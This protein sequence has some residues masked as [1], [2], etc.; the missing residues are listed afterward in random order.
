MRYDYAKELADNV[1]GYII[2]K[3][4][5]HHHDHISVMTVVKRM[6]DIELNLNAGNDPDRNK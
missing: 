1:M 6:I 3:C 4:N 2:A 5:E